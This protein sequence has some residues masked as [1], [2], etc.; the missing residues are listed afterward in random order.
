MRIDRVPILSSHSVVDPSSPCPGEEDEK[1]ED[2]GEKEEEEEDL[3][4]ENMD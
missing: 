4:R 3:D 2:Q 1:E